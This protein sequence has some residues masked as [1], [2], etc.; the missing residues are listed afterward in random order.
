M[1]FDEPP[2]LDQELQVSDED[3]ETIEEQLT[4]SHDEDNGGSDDEEMED[5]NED[6]ANPDEYQDTTNP[7]EV[8]G[9]VLAVVA[10]ALENAWAINQKNK[11]S[12]IFDIINPVRQFKRGAVYDDNKEDPYAEYNPDPDEDPNVTETDED[13]KTQPYNPIHHV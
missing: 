4:P 12:L 3:I 7:K 11:M 5:N 10:P 1:R 6:S 13:G 8:V 9:P 2:V